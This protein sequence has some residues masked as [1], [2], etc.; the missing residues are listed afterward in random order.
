[1]QVVGNAMPGCDMQQS[2]YS[3]ALPFCQ[4]ELHI[5]RQRSALA[6]RSQHSN[7][8]ISILQLPRNQLQQVFREVALHPGRALG[9]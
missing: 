4:L 5:I 2:L 3:L 1:M 7:L 9:V 8:Q 6:C